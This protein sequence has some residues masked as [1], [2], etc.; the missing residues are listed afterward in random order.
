MNTE[1]SRETAQTAQ[2]AA[3]LEYPVTKISKVAGIVETREWFLRDFA[4]G[5]ELTALKRAVK[6]STALSDP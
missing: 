5:R 4:N 3:H 1:F 6:I 2:N